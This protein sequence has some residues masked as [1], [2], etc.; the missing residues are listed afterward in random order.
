MLPYHCCDILQDTRL[1]QLEPA[2]PEE[3]EELG[4]WE[5]G[6]K[7]TTPIAADEEGEGSG[8]ES[9][10]GEEGGG[11]GADEESG[12]GEEEEGSGQD[13]EFDQAFGL[14]DDEDED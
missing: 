14:G 10:G 6:E 2:L 13:D 1:T 8:E 5:E 3:D 7:V 4:N 11:G 12:G 9:E